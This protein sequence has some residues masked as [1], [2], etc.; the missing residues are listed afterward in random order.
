[1]TRAEFLT[2]QK[3]LQHQL[4]VCA[5][6]IHIS[7]D[8]ESYADYTVGCFYD[9]NDKKWKMYHTGERGLHGIWLESENEEEVFDKLYSYISYELKNYYN[10]DAVTLDR[11]VT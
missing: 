4:N 9:E 6:Q 3:D 1:M 11:K 8:Y 10:V 7:I 5:T 2:I